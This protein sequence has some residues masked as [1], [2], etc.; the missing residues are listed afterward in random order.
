MRILITNDD[1]IDSP[2]IAALVEALSVEHEPF[3][4]APAVNRSGVSHAITTYEAITLERRN[5]ARVLSYACS[6]TPADCVFLGAT[7][8]SSRPD[9]VI[10][11]INHG[12][13]LADD[14]NYSG[15]VG[16]AIEGALL[17]IPAIAVSLAVDHDTD[18]ERHWAA[19][20]E[21]TRRCIERILETTQ[22]PVHYWNI[23][24]PNIPI[25][26][27]GGVM[28]TMLGRKKICGRVVG[29][30]HKGATR[31]YRAWESPFE[32]DR[33]TAGTDIAAVHAGYT[34]L[35]PLLLD[36]TAHSV[37]AQASA[38]GG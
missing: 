12:P 11:G 8:L 28:L 1:G 23:N 16:G 6:G 4:V 2:G 29:E 14:V 21:M 26:S 32:T 24:V 19:A 15:T 27:G 13:N 10:S 17:E 18:V 31:Y 3:V 25:N 33:D 7:V 38:A 37:L 34:S 20:A 36:R 9:L 5:D 35:T 22:E 30:E